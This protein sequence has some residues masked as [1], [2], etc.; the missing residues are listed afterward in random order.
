MLER[1]RMWVQGNSSEIDPIKVFSTPRQHIPQET[2]S[3]HFGF[4]KCFLYFSLQ[5]ILLCFLHK[6][7]SYE[8]Q[9]PKPLKN[10]PYSCLWWAEMS[11]FKS[12]SWR[13]KFQVHRVT[14]SRRLAIYLS[15]I[16]AAE[17]SDGCPVDYS[18]LSITNFCLPHFASSKQYDGNSVLCDLKLA[19]HRH[20]SFLLKSLL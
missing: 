12:G 3:F 19:F 17:P 7:N 13:L 20:Y 8:F 4:P 6:V 18:D 9:W 5:R 10:R 16:L 11:C 1:E 2:F 14:L 15:L